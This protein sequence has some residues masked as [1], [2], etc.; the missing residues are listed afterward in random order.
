MAAAAA[1]STTPHTGCRERAAVIPARSRP[2]MTASLWPAP[3]RVRSTRG[4]STASTKTG[5][6][7]FVKER[8]SLGMQ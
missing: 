6:G 1:H 3:I 7:S 5:P 4:L 2:T 8:A